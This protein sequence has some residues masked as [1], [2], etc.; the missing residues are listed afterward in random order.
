[1][2]GSVAK[3]KGNTVIEPGSRIVVPEKK[4][5]HFDWTKVAAITSTLGSLA[6]AAATVVAV[7]K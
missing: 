1:M 3:A 2:N 7:T 6:A 4:E 5:T